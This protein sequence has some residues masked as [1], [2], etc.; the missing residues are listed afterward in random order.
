MKNQ[1]GFS[2]LAVLVLASIV[3]GVALMVLNSGQ[4]NADVKTKIFSNIDQMEFD[5]E[6]KHTFL[7]DKNCTASL[8]GIV[9]NLNQNVKSAPNPIP[10]TLVVKRGSYQVN[11]AGEVQDVVD[12]SYGITIQRSIQYPN[13][14]N[15][16]LAGATQGGNNNPNQTQGNMG[17]V[18]SNLDK[19]RNPEFGKFDTVKI[20]NLSF[21]FDDNIA[22]AQVS[23]PAES[24]IEVTADISLRQSVFEKL[25]QDKTEIIEKLMTKTYRTKVVHENIGGNLSLRR[26]LYCGDIGGAIPNNQLFSYRC[27]GGGNWVQGPA[28][29]S[30]VAIDVNCTNQ[31]LANAVV[32]TSICCGA[33]APVFGC[34]GNNNANNNNNNNNECSM[35]NPNQCTINNFAGANFCVANGHLGKYSTSTTGCPPGPGQCYTLEPSCTQRYIK[36]HP[37]VMPNC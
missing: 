18:N 34:A 24:I 2:I 36:C 9:F 23:G 26:I 16:T 22:N 21:L 13:E 12:S 28:D 32:N 20:H 31:A 30:C 15:G 3:A 29:A 6:L 17:S 10:N 7:V 37:D 8:R 25:N 11:A 27:N 19:F 35:P 33:S 14:K 1:K 5:D 4:Q